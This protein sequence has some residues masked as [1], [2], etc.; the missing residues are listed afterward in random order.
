[1]KACGKVRNC[2]MGTNTKTQSKNNT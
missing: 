2:L 1:M